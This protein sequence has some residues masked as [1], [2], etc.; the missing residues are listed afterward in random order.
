MEPLRG[1]KLAQLPADAAGVEKLRKRDCG[2]E[3]GSGN[4]DGLKLRQH[5]KLLSWTCGTGIH[6]PGISQMYS[7]NEQNSRLVHGQRLLPCLHHTTNP[8]LAQQKPPQ[9][10][11]GAAEM[12]QIRS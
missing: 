1:G 10:S 3:N 4:Q 6:L 5:G 7:M 2:N 12:S 8:S 9:N 11:I